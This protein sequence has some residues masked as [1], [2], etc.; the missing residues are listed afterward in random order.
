M[1]RPVMDAQIRIP[2]LVQTAAVTTLITSPSSTPW[3]STP[4][5][6]DA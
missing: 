3:E 1:K 5:T 2:Q 4:N 6:S